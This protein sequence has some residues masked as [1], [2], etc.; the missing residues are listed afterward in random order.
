MPMSPVR[1]NVQLSPSDLL[2]QNEAV[3]RGCHNVSGPGVNPEKETYRLPP[4]G[5]PPILGVP[6]S[7]GA[8]AAQ[9]LVIS[10][11]RRR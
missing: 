10:T 11:G 3:R 2:L 7:I 4:T 1:E 5:S 9:T 6:V 8:T